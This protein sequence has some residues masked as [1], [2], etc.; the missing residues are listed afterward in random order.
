M[1]GASAPDLASRVPTMIPPTTSPSTPGASAPVTVDLGEVGI[2]PLGSRV[3]VHSFGP[4]E[5]S[6]QPP[7]GSAWLEADLE[8]CLPQGMTREVKLGNIRY[9][10]A[11]EMSDGS[12]IDPE[13]DAD[14]P[15]EV[16]AS[17]GTFRANEC[18]RGPLVFAVPTG[19]RRIPPARRQE[20]CGALAARLTRRNAAD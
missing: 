6:L 12:T 19:R 20:R 10:V 13:A 18:V 16:Y 3:T 7:A 14:S 17:D 1:I 4:G 11:L 5:R 8:W 15:D 9:E 2:T